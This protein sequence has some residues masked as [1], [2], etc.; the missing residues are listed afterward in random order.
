MSLYV[1]GA[2]ISR[3]GIASVTLLHLHGAQLIPDGEPAEQRVQR[4]AH[5][6]GP[7]RRRP[8]HRAR[9]LAQRCQGRRRGPP[10]QVIRSINHHP[11]FL[12]SPLHP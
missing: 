2:G 11:T 3:H 6:E 8:C 12:Q 9:P 5:R 4:G 1:M 10:R 7:P